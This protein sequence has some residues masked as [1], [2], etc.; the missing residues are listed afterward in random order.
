VGCV[1]ALFLL[2]LLSSEKTG[3][4]KA[5]S[6]VLIPLFSLLGVLLPL[7]SFG[8]FPIAVA[9]VSA[10]SAYPAAAS[11]LAGNF[12]FNM[13]VPSADPTFTWR[14]GFARPVFAVCAALLAGF[15]VV[16]VRSRREKLFLG[17]PAGGSLAGRAASLARLALPRAGIFLICGAVL[18]V[19]F[20]STIQWRIL[21]LIAQNPMTSSVPRFFSERNV[22]NRFF[23]LAIGVLLAFMDLARLAG[24]FAALRAR[25]MIAFVVF[26]AALALLLG[27]S[28]FLPVS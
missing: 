8:V 2:W 11:L 7:G 6:G 23:L 13:T 18:S 21:G 17:F 19:L 15:L 10:A 1:L 14:N 4:D 12:L 22:T 25:G 24:V 26:M 3:L 16:A 27:L 28:A 20:R 5:P 9:L